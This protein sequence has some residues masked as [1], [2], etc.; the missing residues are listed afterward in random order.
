MQTPAILPQITGPV[1]AEW[2]LSTWR[3]E[4]QSLP[5]VQALT[6]STENE[7]MALFTYILSDKGDVNV[8]HQDLWEVLV[9]ATALQFSSA[10]SQG[11]NRAEV[12]G[13]QLWATSAVLGDATL[14]AHRLLLVIQSGTNAELEM[15]ELTQ[16]V[17]GMVHQAG[18]QAE[19]VF[20]HGLNPAL[21]ERIQ[22]LMLVS[23]NE[24]RIV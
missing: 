18:D 13:Q 24:G 9:G 12:A 5:A 1:E 10:T 23:R 4:C 19:V 22:V 11:S 16:L 2:L 8:D 3:L 15:D 14:P 17:E 20:G 6:P 7:L 21:G